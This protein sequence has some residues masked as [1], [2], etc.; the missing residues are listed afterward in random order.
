MALRA[1]LERA[2]MQ[3]AR[4]IK[5]VRE[6]AESLGVQMLHEDSVK[7]VQLVGSVDIVVFWIR[8]LS[9]PKYHTVHRECRVRG[10]HHC[11]WMRTSP[12][13]LVSLLARARRSGDTVTG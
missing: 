9:H 12:A 1:W 3:H 7:A 13:G 4:Q 5:P 11:Y 10:I 2:Q 8:Y 6:F